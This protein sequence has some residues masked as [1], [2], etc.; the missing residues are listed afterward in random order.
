MTSNST[1]E[2]LNDI[3]GSIHAWRREISEKFGGDLAAIVS[4]ANRRSEASGRHIVSL[5]DL[6]KRV[7]SDVGIKLE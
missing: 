7:S 3:I 6:M 4:D 5:R 1:T 2:D